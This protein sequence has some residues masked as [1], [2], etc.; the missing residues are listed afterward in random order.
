MNF[1]LRMSENQQE[2]RRIQQYRQAQIPRT[3]A[4]RPPRTPEPIPITSARRP[5]TPYIGITQN[6]ATYDQ[7]LKYR[8]ECNIPREPRRSNRAQLDVDT[9][10]L[11]AILTNVHSNV[12]QAISKIEIR[13]NDFQERSGDRSIR[14]AV[15]DLG[16]NERR[17][18][19]Q[20]REFALAKTQSALHDLK[21]KRERTAEQ[22]SRLLND[23][24]IIDQQIER[25]E[26][27]LKNLSTDTI[28][29]SKLKL[30]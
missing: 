20:I 15:D 12:N 30:I 27:K 25:F 26:Q 17:L 28:A 7:I 21:D 29:Q 4:H 11:D 9:S 2:R 14:I 18:K 5:K 19:D 16:N 22:I 23:Q 6:N 13:R 3:P 24:E 1:Q 8:N 10:F